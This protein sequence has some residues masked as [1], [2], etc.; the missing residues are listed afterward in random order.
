MPNR[1]VVSATEYVRFG[2]LA[3]TST[4]ASI[5]KLLNAWLVS[6]SKE[7][8]AG[9]VIQVKLSADAA[10]TL[11]DLTT[12]CEITLAADTEKII[13]ALDALSLQ[14]KTASTATGK[15]ELYIQAQPVQV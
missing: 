13:P 5:R 3:I 1:Q 11:K 2:Q 9:Q 10:V 12:T 4:Y 7:L 14:I 6:V 15:V 8:P